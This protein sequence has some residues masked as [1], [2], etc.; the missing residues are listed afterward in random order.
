MMDIKNLEINYK[1]TNLEL[2]KF[3]VPMVCLVTG[4]VSQPRETRY[5]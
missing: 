5:L 4:C 3:K 1:F 2:V